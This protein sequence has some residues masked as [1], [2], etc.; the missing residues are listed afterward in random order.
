MQIESLYNWYSS[1]Q[2]QVRTVLFTLLVLVALY[3]IFLT[4]RI[5]VFSGPVVFA[6]VNFPRSTGSSV[7]WNWYASAAVPEEEPEEQEDLAVASISAEL[8]GVVIAGDDSVATVAV[9]RKP[10]Q[11][12]RIGDELER[13]VTLEEVNPTRV[14][15]SQSGTRRQILLK[16]VTGAARNRSE[17]DS[18]IRV[19]NA[20]VPSGAGFSLPGVGRSSLVN[21]EGGGSGLKLN[22]I[23]A[24][25]ADLAD[26]QEDDIVLNISGTPV[27]D[28]FSNPLLFQQFS[29]ETSLPMTVL[30]DG[31]E[32]EV[33]VNAAS[34]FQRII[35]QIGAGLIQ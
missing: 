17:E 24:D 13:N 23:S 14:V 7:R 11:V 28:L 2:K 33:Y 34:L 12:Y 10:A 15:I 25:I 26:L 19:N 22:Q 6:E 1:N 9:S 35:P 5:L 16:D 27:A 31:S 30:R 20:P 32:E 18:L 29:Q 3:F 8:L 21:V 4:V